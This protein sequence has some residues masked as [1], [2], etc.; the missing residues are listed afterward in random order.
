MSKCF[1]TNQS[2]NSSQNIGNI[3]PSSGPT[4]S[5]SIRPQMHIMA[6]DDMKLPIFNVNGSMYLEKHWFLCEVVWIVRQVHDDVIKISQMI[7]TF[8]GQAID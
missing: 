1:P 3:F 5:S 4:S 8:R 6:R 7:M 2:N